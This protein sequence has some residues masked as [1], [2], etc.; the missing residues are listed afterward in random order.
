MPTN[1]I[2]PYEIDNIIGKKIVEKLRAGQ[3]IEY[4][5]LES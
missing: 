1:G 3:H 5:H 4:K 2:P